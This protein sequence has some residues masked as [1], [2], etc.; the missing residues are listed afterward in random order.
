MKRLVV[1][2]VLLLLC[3]SFPSSL[4]ARNGV[5]RYLTKESTVDMKNMNHIFIGWVDMNPDEWALHHYK[6]KAEW[7]DVIGSLNA[8]FL[9]SLQVTYLPGRTITGAK[10]KGDENAAGN[11]LYIKFSDVQVDY[12]H[13]HLILAIHFID[14][15]TN[16][17]IASIPVRPYYG[18]DWG[19]AN[20]LK[21]ALDEVGTKLQVEVTGELQEKKKK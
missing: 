11:D 17:E 8:S 10:D 1:T 18:N 14:P 5:K 15:K 2:A 21:S 12:D 6:D 20:Y 3:I 4:E 9:R 13:Y 16:Q 7:A 19:L